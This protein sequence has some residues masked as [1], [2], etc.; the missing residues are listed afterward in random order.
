MTQL[1]F[2]S[3]SHALEYLEKFSSPGSIVSKKT[4]YGVI[5]F[6]DRSSSPDTYMIEIIALKKSFFSK[7]NARFLVGDTKNPEL[8][9][10]LKE[11]DLVVWGCEEQ[12]DPFSIGILL[13]KC[14]LILDESSLNFIISD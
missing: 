13:Y 7:K 10:D 11:G 4:F 12:K 1:T 3:G 8:I 2:K 9:K 6:I 5:K 14:D